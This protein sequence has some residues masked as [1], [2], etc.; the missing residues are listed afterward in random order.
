MNHVNTKQSCLAQNISQ[1][2]LVAA[3]EERGTGVDHT[4]EIGDK[5]S[6]NNAFFHASHEGHQIFR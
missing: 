4:G 3:G 1:F 5:M 2:P 6:R